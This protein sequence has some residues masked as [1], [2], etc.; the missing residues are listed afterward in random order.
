V[1]GTFEVSPLLDESYETLVLVF[2][3]S[4]QTPFGHVSVASDSAASVL[5]AGD[6]SAGV[7]HGYFPALP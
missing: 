1:E 2:S 4:E 3:P 5:D 6:D 7:P